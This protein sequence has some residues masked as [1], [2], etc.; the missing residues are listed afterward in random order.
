MDTDEYLMPNDLF[1]DPE[2]YEALWK[3]RL[4]KDNNKE[5]DLARNIVS[6]LEIE[7]E[8]YPIMIKDSEKEV[9]QIRFSTD[10]FIV[11]LNDEESEVVFSSYDSVNEYLDGM[12]GISKW[13]VP[14]TVFA[15]M[16]R[17]AYIRK[18]PDKNEWCVY[19][20]D[21]SKTIGCYDSEGSAKKRLKQ[22]EYFKRQG[23]LTIDEVKSG[24]VIRQIDVG[25]L[26][27]IMEVNADTLSVNVI[28]SDLRK[29]MD[30][31]DIHEDELFRFKK[32]AQIIDQGFDTPRGTYW[33]YPEERPDLDDKN[34][35]R[36]RRQ[37]QDKATEKKIKFDERETI[38]PD[39]TDKVPS[40]DME[41][42]SGGAIG[43]TYSETEKFEVGAEPT[44]KDYNQSKY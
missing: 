7:V 43:E 33:G 15:K 11:S 29:T 13:Y 39:R 42:G 37:H 44:F 35:E 19:S 5:I 9:G 32:V 16:K 4:I 12:F 41:R 23:Q 2:I 20:K 31:G 14:E 3:I 8:S 1:D 27:L 38:L 17:M 30:F 10:K 28:K 25:D 18:T 34:Q 24:D 21:G 36:W 26:Y 40:K 6:Q 22:V